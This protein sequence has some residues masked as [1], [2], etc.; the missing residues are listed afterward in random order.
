MR[1]QLTRRSDYAIRACLHL[2]SGDG[3]QPVSSRLIAERMSIPDRFLPHVLAD[4][5]R[6]GLVEATNGKRG[7]YRLRRDPARL[8]LLELIE[9]VEGRQRGDRC[10]LEGRPCDGATPCALHAVWAEA[11]TAFV[12][13]LAGTSLADVADVAARR[14]AAAQAAVPSAAGAAVPS[15]AGAAVPS[16]AGAAVPSAAGAA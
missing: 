3:G 15:A 9:T 16:A 8:S 13:V 14:R 12:D 6:A 10:V 11:Q 4:L 5:A 2:A 1:L 7:G